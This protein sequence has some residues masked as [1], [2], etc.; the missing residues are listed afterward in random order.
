MKNTILAVLFFSTLFLTFNNCK[1]D[2]TDNPIPT[3]KY[4]SIPLKYVEL[5]PASNKISLNNDNYNDINYFDTTW[6]WYIGNDSYQG[7][8]YN[9]YVLNPFVKISGL[10][11]KNGWSYAL[12]KDSLIDE[13]AYWSNEINILEQ[14]EY[15]YMLPSTYLGLKLTKNNKTYYGWLH[16]SSDSKKITEWAL[17]TSSVANRNIYAGIKKK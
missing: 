3:P 5:I 1:K 17:D 12:D 15:P 13:T 2:K 6:T 16:L 14:D 8:I 9:F 7:E 4:D 10:R 11:I